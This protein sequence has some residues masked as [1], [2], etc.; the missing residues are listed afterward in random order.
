MLFHWVTIA[1]WIFHRKLSDLILNTSVYIFLEQFEQFFVEFILDTTVRGSNDKNTWEILSRM[2]VSETSTNRI[3]RE[4][5]LICN[6][7]SY[8]DTFISRKYPQ[9]IRPYR[10]RRTHTRISSCNTETRHHSQSTVCKINVCRVDPR[11]NTRKSIHRDVSH[12]F[13]PVLCSYPSACHANV[14]FHVTNPIEGNS[15]ANAAPRS[16][17]S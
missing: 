3:E 11:R 5:V 4:C 1:W 10:G 7:L 9:W 17:S 16:V 2:N 6:C 15:N 14:K 13:K 12:K 8:I